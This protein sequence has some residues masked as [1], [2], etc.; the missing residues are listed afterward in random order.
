M[1]EV[2]NGRE[3]NFTFKKPNGA[4]DKWTRV[5]WFRWKSQND[6][7]SNMEHES[8]LGV[9]RTTARSFGSHLLVAFAI[10][11]TKSSSTIHKKINQKRALNRMKSPYER[12]SHG[13]SGRAGNFIRTKNENEANFTI[14][15]HVSSSSVVCCNM[16]LSLLLT[17]HTLHEQNFCRTIQ[18]KGFFPR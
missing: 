1:A 2:S 6:G 13:Y 12:R 16:P 10:S 5:E 7:S 9:T 11:N 15:L 4:W 3:M 8:C 18:Q 17:A 14:S